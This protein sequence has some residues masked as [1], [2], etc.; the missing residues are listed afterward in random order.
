MKITRAFCQNAKTLVK[1][2]ESERFRIQWPRKHDKVFVAMSGGVDSSYSAY[3]LKRQGLNVEGVFMRNWVDEEDAPGGCPAERDWTLV[4][5]ICKQL[6]IPL[7]RFNFEKDYWNRVFEPSLEQYERGCTPN[8]DVPCNRYVKFGALYEALEKEVC[9][10]DKKWW[11]ATGHYAKTMRSERNEGVALCLPKDRWKDQTLFLCTVQEKAL[12]RTIFPLYNLMKKDVK[13]MAAEAGLQESAERLESQGLCFVS[14]NVGSH[15]RNF[16]GRY[17][18]FSNDPIRVVAKGKVVGVYPPSTGVWSF[19][20][21]ERCGFSLPQGDPEFQGRWYVWKKE[22]STNTIYICQGSE[23]PLLYRN[24]IRVHPWTWSTEWLRQKMSPPAGQS[25]ECFV[26]VR[27][28][29]LLEPAK[30]WLEED[31]G[32]VVEFQKPQRALTPGQVLAMYREEV[33]L[34]GGSI[35]DGE[36]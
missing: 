18:K 31:G 19:T 1:G 11:L 24:R 25:M 15:F 12:E 6:E 20:I 26:R 5:K 33:C 17:L 30:A 21:G 8:P 3:L 7:R 28:Q 22:S 14:P 27:H 9:S 10:E 35:A 4:Q 36:P 13:R 34:G 29:Q 2:W 23:N 16:L 32:C